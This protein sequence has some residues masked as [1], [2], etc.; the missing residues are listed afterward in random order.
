MTIIITTNTLL[1]LGAVCFAVAFADVI[2]KMIAAAIFLV[3][4]A[5]VI[6]ASMEVPAVAIFVAF[7]V[8]S[9]VLLFALP[10]GKDAQ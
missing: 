2:P 3:L 10:A 9:V 6:A 4:G 8:G 7:I 1:V 5:V